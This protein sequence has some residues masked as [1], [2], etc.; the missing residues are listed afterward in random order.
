M[1]EGAGE[2]LDTYLARFRAPGAEVRTPPALAGGPPSSPPATLRRRIKAVAPPALYRSAAGGY[3]AASRVTGRNPGRDRILPDF[4]VIG[5]A[6]CGTTS[7]YDWLCEHPLIRRPTTNGHPR[8]E[9][10]FFDYNWEDGVDAYRVNFALESER[11][12]FTRAHGRP[13][14]TGEA[15]ASYASNPWAPERVARTIP[16]AKLIVTMRNPVDRAFSAFHMSRRERLE[17][18]ESFET[19]LALEAERLAPEEERQRRDP[20]YNPSP[21]PLGYWSYLQRGRYAEHLTR[22]VEL[23]DRD[24][25]L[26]LRFE[27]LAAEPQRTLDRVYDF[28]GLPRHEH[29]AFPALNTGGGYAPMLQETRAHLLEYFR[30]HNERLAELTGTD[31][32]WGEE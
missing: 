26:F 22:W 30:P 21:P 3:R 11:E 25:M 4:L 2:R 16:A 28:L 6:K 19:A 9:L 1:I 24:S 18:Y 12:Q 10:L 27:D 32:G 29:E 13:F 20:R 14:L 15:T 31:F 7:L 8:K 23:F 5:F 17:E